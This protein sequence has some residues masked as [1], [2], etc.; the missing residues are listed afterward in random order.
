VNPP[1]AAPLN[2]R[3]FF[4]LSALAGGGLVL[5]YCLKSGR[6]AKAATDTM[7]GS[8]SPSAF[9]R[10]APDGT[11]TIVSARPEIGQGIKTALPMVIA[12]ELGVN[13]NQV[14]VISAPLN[15]AFG[16]QTAGGS[17]STPTSYQAMRKIG[18]TARLM[19]VRAAA[20]TW[21]VP[22]SECV[23][24]NG[25]VRHRD[26]GRTLGY[27][28]LAATAATMPVPDEATVPLKD[29]KDFTLLGSRVGGVDNPKIVTGQRLFGLDQKV[30][31]MKY[32]V[33]QKCPVFSGKPLSANL[34]HLKT[35]PGVRD[36]FII[37]QKSPGLTGLLP[38]VAIVADSTWSAIKARRELEVKWEEGPNAKDSW[39]AFTAQAKILGPKPGAERLRAD[40]NVLA[41]FGAAAKTIT[42][43]YSYPWVAH[44]TLEPQNCTADVRKDRA[45]LWIPTQNPEGARQL[46]AQV[47]GMAPEKISVT[48]TRSG[49]AFG[50]RGDNDYAAEAAVISQQ[51]GVPIQLVWTREDDMQHDH[52]RP[53][54]FHFLGG[55]LDAQG[56]LSAWRHHAIEF[57][58][59]MT[60]DDFPGRFVAHCLLESTQLP[61][62][63]PIGAW[64]APRDNTFAWATASFIDELAHAAGRDPIEFSLELLSARHLAPLSPAGSHNPPYNPERMRGV[65]Q[66][67]AEKSD[68]S[69]PLA[70]GR[71]RGLGYYY[72]HRGYVAEVAEVTVTKA[73]KLTVDRV[74]AAVDVGAQIINLSGAEA[75]VQGSIIDGLS[76]AWRQ[77]LDLD[78]GRIVQ[79]N[80]HEYAML[81]LP[82]A[83][84]QIDIHFH[85][86]DFPVTGL[87]EPCLPPIA[88]AVCNAVFAATG[89][90]I[91]EL[92][93][94][95]TDLSWT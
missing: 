65:I 80:F 51:A 8:F 6:I 4:K 76:A 62:G 40:G 71:G 81:R 55:A 77:E 87:G 3:S 52:Y 54:G 69:K 53:G 92:P 17:M 90:R 35:L 2:R 10:I 9:L 43:S 72:S 83:P 78:R 57:N 26:S 59:A 28:D 34:E 32:A 68:W 95:R 25:R 46:V 84:R 74:V 93:F 15:S 91:R 1:L 11:V 61:H 31:G 29:P 66:L 19:L 75:Q 21:G 30:P 88:P 56:K 23:A 45:E 39:A 47:I 22:E 12:E 27:G 44:A 67:V 63:I 79:S 64:R 16:Q 7:E 42:A 38:G 18:A 58:A 41:A 20:K 82:E 89:K 73:G 49:G 33:Y 24:E 86:T 36:A 70:R 37:H 50:R 60:G 48:T 13:W 5:A 94:S 85:K 14:K